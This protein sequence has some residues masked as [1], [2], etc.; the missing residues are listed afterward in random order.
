MNS[1]IESRLKGIHNVLWSAYEAGELLSSSSKGS[2]RET[3]ISLFLNE[4]LP[5][6][7]RFGTGDITDSLMNNNKERRSG[8]IDIVIE[9][10]WA[11][12]FPVAGASAR[13]YPAEAVGVAIEI[14]SNLS[15]QWAEVTRTAKALSPLRQRL[16]GI[17]TSGGSLNVL[18][19]TEEPIP[20]YAVGYRGWSTSN[21]VKEKVKELNDIDGIL[22]LEQKIFAWSDRLQFIGRLQLAQSEL[23]K[24]QKGEVHKSSIAACARVFD[25]TK[26]G[27][28][29][30]DIAITLNSE[31][32]SSRD[33][34]FEDQDPLPIVNLGEWNKDNVQQLFNCFDI[35]VKVWTEEEALLQ[36]V[37]HLHGEVGKRAAMSVDLSMYAK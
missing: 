5:P 7:Y 33:L 29:P 37:A 30:A 12:S 10:P 16:N 9:M 27:T 21:V 24:K 4:V 11:P 14:K 25:L 31:K 34:H 2:E 28:S 15:S 32:F 26:Q 8:Q 17:S 18:D 20:F 13:L 36:F 3:F 19:E 22:V 23:D 35:K 1:L 6:I